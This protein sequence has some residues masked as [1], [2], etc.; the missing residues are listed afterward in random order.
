MNAWRK[1]V[2]FSGPGTYH[3][4]L[5]TIWEDVRVGRDSVK[6]VT[7]RD[8]GGKPDCYGNLFRGR[9]NHPRNLRKRAQVEVERFLDTHPQRNDVTAAQ[10]WAM[11]DARET[12]LKGGV[13]Q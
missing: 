6:M 13:V 3:S 10:K 2:V 9:K 5:P 7:D 4:E 1:M 12:Q 8:L 11:V